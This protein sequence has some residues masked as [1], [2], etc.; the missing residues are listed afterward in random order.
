M[1]TIVVHD[2]MFLR[3][4]SPRLLGLVLSFLM[5]DPSSFRLQK[6][7]LVSLQETVE[8]SRFGELGRISRV[9]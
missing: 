3:V 8:R 5:P 7:P 2:P 6:D 9:G 1:A 4:G